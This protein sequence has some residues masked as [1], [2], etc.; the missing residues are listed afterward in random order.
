MPHM[1]TRRRAK[2]K[3]EWRKEGLT[4]IELT[5]AT[6]LNVQ[7]YILH[8]GLGIDKGRGERFTK[9]EVRRI[10]VARATTRRSMLKIERDRWNVLLKYL[11]LKPL[12]DD[13]RRRHYE[14]P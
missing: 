5:A 1:Q 8:A 13:G 7:G 3:P 4:C 6:G 12:P 9:A 14:K 2:F 10:G 11:K